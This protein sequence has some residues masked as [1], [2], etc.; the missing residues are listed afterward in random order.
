MTYRPQIANEG[1]KQ[2][3]ICPKNGYWMA[4]VVVAVGQLKCG[5]FRYCIEVDGVT[6]TGLS[7]ADLKLAD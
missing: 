3:F 7:Y 1:D 6:H 5:A 4:G 2:A